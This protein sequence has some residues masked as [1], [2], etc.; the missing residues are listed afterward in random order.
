MGTRARFGGS[1]RLCVQLAIQSPRL[2][3]TRRSI[4]G[5][6]TVA[7]SSDHPWDHGSRPIGNER[8]DRCGGRR[9]GVSHGLESPRSSSLRRRL[10]DAAAR[11]CTAQARWRRRARGLDDDG[12]GGSSRPLHDPLLSRFLDS[13][14]PVCCSPSSHLP[15]CRRCR[16]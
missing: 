12:Q 15:S 2:D 8:R 16:A 14:W 4:R 1:C 6:W 11:C 13:A 7:R 3:L 5:R 10:T 9:A